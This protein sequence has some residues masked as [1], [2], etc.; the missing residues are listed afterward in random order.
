ME[1]WIPLFDIFLKSP[2]PEAEASLW[3][4]QAFN[5]SSSSM[6]S[7]INRSSFFSLLKRPCDVIDQGSSQITKKVMFIETLPSMVQSR[8]LS[9]LLSEHQRF[10][11]RDLSCLAREMLS[12]SKEVNFWVQSAARNLLGKMS[13]PSY[14]WI[15]HLDLD[16]VDDSISDEF[17]SVPGWLAEKAGAIGSVLPWLPISLDD[18][19]S[20]MLFVDSENEKETDCSREN[21]EEDYRET[22]GDV[23][24]YEYPR[25]LTIPPEVHEMAS[26]LK[27]QI[28]SSESSP[29]ISALCYEIRKLCLENG[30]DVLGI[31]SLIEPWNAD[32]ESASL[33]LSYLP[34]GTE[35]EEELGWPS[36]VLCSVVLPKFLVLE[37]SASRAVMSATIDF[38]KIHRTA[39][40]YALV[41]PLIFRKEGINNFMCEVIS[42]VLK[43]CWH[44]GHISAFCQKLLC[45]GPEDRRLLS[46]PCHQNLICEEVTWN[47][48]LFN[49]FQNILIHGVPLSQDSVDHL[50]LKARESAE[51]FPKSIKFGN[52]LLHFVAKCAPMLK[53]HKDLLSETVDCTNSLV[54]KSISSKLSA[55]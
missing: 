6:A 24:A 33:F 53:A 3:L 21:M 55:L 49:L 23:E 14:E 8:I 9:F 7:P 38:C 18:F 47:E 39:A 36:Q 31:L 48:S 15:S 28:A 10:C 45:G 20:K 51:R 11:P 30:R 16:S 19:D 44:L 13:K 41:F 22:M 5:S 32:D 46:L 40:E 52:F 27:S 17:D 2:A 43:E 42:R 26:N 35:E 29:E 50:V 34:S 12:G 25:N 1:K 54:T 37:K 4:D